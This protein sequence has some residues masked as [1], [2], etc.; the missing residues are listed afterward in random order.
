M[1]IPFQPT[2][3]VGAI[4]LALGFT[5]SVHAAEQKI[6]QASLDTIVVTA[7]RS[8]EKSENVPARISIIEPAILEQS[9]I[10]SLPN[11]LKK[12][13]ALNVA[14]LGGYGQQ[15]SIFM[16][17]TS[18]S[19]TLVLRDGMRLNTALS[20]INGFISPIFAI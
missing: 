14:Q 19:H 6:A 12:E 4:A 9:P 17:G 2:A 20:T 11:L 7:T 1:S 8:E 5:S 10:A 13:A 18:S 16:R 15:S 3:L